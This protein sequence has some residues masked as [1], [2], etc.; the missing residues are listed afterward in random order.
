MYE[1]SPCINGFALRRKVKIQT[2]EIEISGGAL[3]GSWSIYEY[4]RTWESCKR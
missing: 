1:N 4:R 2:V 3:N